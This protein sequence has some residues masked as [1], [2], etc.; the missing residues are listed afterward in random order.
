MFTVSIAA[1]AHSG[2]CPVMSGA[3]I[4]IF[5]DRGYPP[6]RAEPTASQRFQSGVVINEYR[7]N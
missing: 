3:G 2:K 4:P 1:I 5:A 6:R 7:L